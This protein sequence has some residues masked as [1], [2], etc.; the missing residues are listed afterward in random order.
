MNPA[1][2]EF[3]GTDR[4]RIVRQ[5]GAG[6]FGIV[7]EAVDR[8]RNAR[9]ALKMLY[10]SEAA[11]LY[12]LKK[13]FRALAE[14][15]HP[16]LVSLY[17]L[18]SH[19]GY[20]F[21]TMQLVNGQDFLRAMSPAVSAGSEAHVANVDADGFQRL[22]GAL[23]QLADGL[24]Y[25]HGL[26]KLHRDIKSA[27]V[28]VTPDGRVV[29]LD[30]GLVT[31]LDLESVEQS[32]NLV[33]TPAYMAPEQLEGLGATAATDWYAVGVLMFS[34][35][36]GRYPFIGSVVDVC[37]AK[38]EQDP[39]HPRDFAS[40]I[41]DDLNSLCRDLLARDPA[42]RPSGEEFVVRLRSPNRGAAAFIRTGH[43]VRASTRFVGRRLELESLD[44]AY[45][46]SKQ[47]QATTVYLHGTSGIGKT[48]LVRHFLEELQRRELDT[49]I[50]A[51]RCYE[52]ESVPYKA[53]DSLV[54]SL[55]R[56]LRDLPPAEVEG[57]LPRDIIP[58]ARLFPVLH[59]V[60]AVSSARRRVR[61]VPESQELRRRAFAAF[62]ELLDRI[63]DRR[64]VVIFIDDLQWGDADSAAL[65]AALLEPPGPPPILLIASY[66]SEE[67]NRILL[68]SLLEHRPHETVEGDVRELVVGELTQAEARELSRTLI[69]TGTTESLQRAETVAQ[70][71]RGNPFLINELVRY[72][73]EQAQAM[74][75]DED[76]SV[77]KV[78]IARVNVLPENARRLLELLAVYGAPLQVQVA[79]QSA[80]LASGELEA[81]AVLR[82]R[83][84]IRVRTSESA[85][86]MEIYHDRIRE[87]II[88]SL[89][90][91]TVRVHHRRL[92]DALEAAGHPDPEP[93]AIHFHG[94]GMDS[95]AAH[96][97]VLAAT[98]ATEAMA[99]D[100][101][102]R[103]YRF[104]LE[105][106]PIDRPGVR[107]LNAQ[108]GNALAYA[109]R[110]RE[111]AEAY[112]AGAAAADDSL[113]HLEL[114]RCAGEQ[115]LRSGH[116][117]DGLTVMTEVL[118]EIGIA[119][120]IT[121][122]ASLF[123]LLWHR[124]LIRIVGLRYRARDEARIAPLD[125]FKVDA[126]WSVAL[127]VGMIS[128]IR[129]AD[130]QARQ[131]LL[132][133][134]IGD[135]RRVAR[136]I[137]AEVAYSAIPGTRAA[138]RTEKL[139]TLAEQLAHRVADPQAIGLVYV[140]KG[141]A[142]NMQGRWKESLEI[143]ERA[144]EMLRVEARGIAWELDLVQLY[145][146]LDLQF[147][148][149]LSELRRRLGRYLKEARERDDLN[150][151]T[152]LRTRLGYV[153]YLAADEP[154]H[155]E[156]EVALGIGSWSREGFQ[157]QHYY[158][159]FAEAEVLLYK[160]QGLVAW[161]ALDSRWS[162]LKRSFLLHSQNVRVEALQLR[163][164]AALAA[165]CAFG[166]DSRERSKFLRIADKQARHVLRETAPAAS[167]QALLVRAG[168]AAMRGRL[169]QAVDHL[170]AAERACALLDMNLHAAVARRRRG[171]LISGEAGAAAVRE[172]D[173]WMTS[174][175]IRNPEQMAALLAPGE[176]EA[177]Q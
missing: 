159:M 75:F 97:A 70:E 81:L 28:L 96:Y 150:A 137:A 59:Q 106:E 9:V 2:T 61:G 102:A 73:L 90:S 176:Y 6:G 24:S 51:G 87:T 1:P 122:R 158:A 109:G 17:E 14:I 140:M 165:A 171:Q 33:G 92:A 11:Q 145:S 147:M 152:N 83:R 115:L 49:L 4:F 161:R 156:S 148:G 41:P 58:L 118:R 121:P 134:R 95:R 60:E 111:A 124:M 63:T 108:L 173:A 100:R 22:R 164:R 157:L 154:D 74:P 85:E 155:A 101:A 54:D 123:S 89:S 139:L 138:R 163:A 132:A 91:D 113:A 82:A 48:A 36:T 99:F 66:R 94:A 35:L 29:L 55:S 112:L 162:D 45:E 80:D 34:A 53:V 20:W 42:Q 13:E 12:R 135:L 117:D 172:A 43:A 104:A 103:L 136:A 37:Q 38:R 52:R 57:L 18:L 144:E 168:A 76:L 177:R 119:L 7:Y 16:N 169:R 98:Q 67:A 167:A 71:A 128:T 56:Y 27:N 8:E 114:R 19:D 78:V 15:S 125:L 105:L 143:A 39:P 170:S 130:F 166:S 62:R 68:R 79:R 21:F 30:F 160:E 10:R 47:G 46:S 133:C 5:I 141:M 174:R 69:S 120:D 142:A 126:C 32:M 116:I 77:E 40:N 127:H 93:L 175:E 50:L 129:G 84:L 146:L 65:L 3:S 153:P 72:S 86:Q 23:T 31:E 107:R 44:A 88:K 26:G 110:G 149:E 64:P 25:L 131:L 151:I